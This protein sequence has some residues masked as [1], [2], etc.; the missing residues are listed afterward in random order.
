MNLRQI[1]NSITSGVNPN[2]DAVIMLN[3]GFDITDDGRQVPSYQE[4]NVIAQV[5]GLNTSDLLHLD[6]FNQQGQYNSVYINGMLDAQIRSLAKGEDKIAFTPQGEAKT[7]EWRIIKV[8]E[9]YN[10]LWT[11]VIVCRQ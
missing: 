2:Q 10:D 7:V 11:K 8:V 3:Q 4:V 6:G 9:R 1:A 5:Q